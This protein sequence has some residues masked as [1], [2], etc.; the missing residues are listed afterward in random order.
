MIDIVICRSRTC[1]AYCGDSH[2]GDGE[3][4][5]LLPFLTVIRFSSGTIRNAIASFIILPSLSMAGVFAI[6]FV[7]RHLFN[8]LCIAKSPFVNIANF[9]FFMPS[10]DM[11]LCINFE[12]ALVHSCLLTE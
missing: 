10:S 11:I 4:V 1:S 12:F 3:G 8:N 2:L 5:I 9:T 7:F 6:S